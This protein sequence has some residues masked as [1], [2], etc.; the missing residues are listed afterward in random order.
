MS[1]IKALRRTPPDMATPSD[2]DKAG[3]EKIVKALNG[4]VAD[5]FTLY[6]KTKNFHWHVSGPHFRGY[7]VMLDEQADQIF[8]A[9]D[10]LAERVRK[11]GGTTVRSIGHIAKL[12]TL[13]D[14]DAERVA[15]L[16][17]LNQLLADNKSVAKAMREAHSLCDDHEDA[18]TASLLEIYIDETERR[19]WFLFESSRAADSTGH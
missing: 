2:L 1:D 16:D 5:A 3:V 14:S 4:L 13:E 9:I 11:I 6:V 12:R 7:H 15:P 10:P 17:M 8:A 18:A 19:T